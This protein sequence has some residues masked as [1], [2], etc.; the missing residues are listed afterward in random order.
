MYY[1]V[2]SA[3]NISGEGLNSTQVSAIPSSTVPVDVS[4][5]VSSGALT[6]SWPADHLGWRLQVQT[7]TLSAGLGANW[8]DVAG[9]SS[10]N[11]MSF[12]VDS[13]SGSV[14]LRLI[15]P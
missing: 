12:P 8:F 7:N 1:Y 6:L 9:S 10:T 15:Y 5:S 14:F 2:V 3:A 13:S 11:S 4:M